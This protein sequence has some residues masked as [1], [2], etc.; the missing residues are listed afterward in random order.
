MANPHSTL[1]L[2]VDDD[3]VVLRT[4]SL[5]L[6]DMNGF[7]VCRR[8]K[9]YIDLPIVMLTAV[10]T[11]ESVVQGLDRFAE[12][13]IIKP[14]SYRQLVARIA[15]VLKRASTARP[16]SDVVSLSPDV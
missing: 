8:I 1:I 3:P 9:Q 12:D 4:L 15:R 11:E 13:Y 7:D 2:I 10:G 14:F 16:E 6:P 5:K